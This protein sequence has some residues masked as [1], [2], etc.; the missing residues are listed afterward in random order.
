MLGEIEVLEKYIPEP[1]ETRKTIVFT[2]S[3]MV[4]GGAGVLKGLAPAGAEGF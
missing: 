3:W 1:L 4:W 2:M